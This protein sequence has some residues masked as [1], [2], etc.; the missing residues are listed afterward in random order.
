[1]NGEVYSDSVEILIFPFVL[2]GI[3]ITNFIHAM[4]YEITGTAGRWVDERYLFKLRSF[5]CE[6]LTAYRFDS[7]SED[8]KQIWKDK[9][10]FRAKRQ[11]QQV[12]PLFSEYQ[13]S[14]STRLRSSPGEISARDAS[15]PQLLMLDSLRRQPRGRC[16]AGWQ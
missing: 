10:I 3:N 7:F 15:S 2:K 9:I 13:C 12:L 5:D 8:G 16:A 1:M 6:F 4:V 14:R 11:P